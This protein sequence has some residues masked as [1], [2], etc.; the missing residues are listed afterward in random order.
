MF[1]SLIHSVGKRDAPVGF[2]S[3]TISIFPIH[4]G[5]PSET[6]EAG[7]CIDIFSAHI[8]NV[9][10]LLQYVHRTNGSVLHS[11]REH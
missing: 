2:F 9:P 8:L 5:T 6:R 1:L 10:F 7:V 3:V 4:A 11:N